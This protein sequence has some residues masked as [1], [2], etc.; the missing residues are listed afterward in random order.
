MGIF[1]WFGSR[2]LRE[3]SGHLG[4]TRFFSIFDEDDAVEAIKNAL[5]S[6]TI[7]KEQLNH[8]AARK[9]ISKIKNEFSDP[10]LELDRLTCS[11]FDRYEEL[12]AESNAFDF[13]DLIEKTVRLL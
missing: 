11:V 2:M 12:L 4:R 1:H 3:E 7:P 13:D 10:D 5:T 8:F 9:A 6:L